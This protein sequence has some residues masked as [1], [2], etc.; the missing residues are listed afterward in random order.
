MRYLKPALTSE[1]QADRLIGRGLVVNDKRLLVQRLQTVN[2]YRLSGYWYSFKNIDSITGNESFQKGTT[3]EAVWQRYVF[4][5]ELKLLVMDALET[6]EVAVLRTQMVEQFALL[7]GAFGYIQTSNFQPAISS[8]RHAKLLDELAYTVSKSREEFVSRFKNKY[9]NE[10]H[11]PLWMA[12]E[13]MTFGQLLTFYNG[14]NLVEKQNLAKRYDVFAPVFDSWL[15]SLNFIRNVCAHHQRLW[16][17]LIPLQPLIPYARHRPDWHSPYTP[18]SNRIFVILCILQDMM[19]HI[20]PRNMWKYRLQTLLNTYP[21]I[22][23]REMG[24]PD[25]WQN[26]KL[27]Q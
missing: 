4:D 16:N 13:L 6:I 19:K 18:N 1:Q 8:E 22:P 23:H 10:Q 24:F 2:Y 3:F 12:A 9:I 5:R 7:H 25:S 27:W 14:L 21:D 17:R 20:E 15:L 11:L 26:S